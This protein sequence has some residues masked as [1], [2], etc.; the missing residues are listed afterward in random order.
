MKKLYKY[1]VFVIGILAFYACTDETDFPSVTEDGTD[2]TL[3]LNVQTQAHKDVVVSRATKE[4]NTLYDLHFYV[5]NEAGDLTGYEKIIFE[6]GNNPTTG[7]QDKVEVKIRTKTG[8]SYIYALANINNGA[9]YRL[10][11]TDSKL[12]NVT[13]GS[14]IDA[15]TKELKSYTEDGLPLRDIIEKSQL[16][17]TT[18]LGIKYNRKYTNSRS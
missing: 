16:T 11:D 17:R 1:I 7:Q 3:T 12:L 9:N 13:I 10:N 14:T 4:E 2:V 15:T 18:F 8:K 6:D 5:F